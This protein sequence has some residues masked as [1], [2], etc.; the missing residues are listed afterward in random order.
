[1]KKTRRLVKRVDPEKLVIK[2][3]A[4]IMASYA[5]S[6]EEQRLILASIQKAHSQKEPLNANLIKMSLSVNEY[7]D[8]YNV[9][10]VTAYKALSQSSNRLWERSIVIKDEGKEREIRWLQEKA[11]YDSGKVELTFSNVISKH[12]SEVVTTQTAY[13]LAQ[14]TQLRTQHSIR[15]FEIFQAVIDHESQE[16]EWQVSIDDFKEKLKIQDSYERWIDLKK[17]V[18]TP[19]LNMINKNTSL[20][21][22]WKVSDKEGKR[23]TEILFIIFETD[24]LTLSLD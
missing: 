20:K 23:I 6:V 7:A 11:K 21:V 24:Q 12:I 2:D 15:L 17:K 22:E 9:E 13:R 1:M 16:G 8:I 14:A 5:L 10:L 19:A 18:I 4:L 3:N